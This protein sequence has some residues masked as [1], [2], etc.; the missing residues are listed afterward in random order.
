[1]AALFHHI[2]PQKNGLFCLFF[3]GW[4]ERSKKEKSKRKRNS[5]NF[6]VKFANDVT[7]RFNLVFSV[8]A[9]TTEK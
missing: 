5:F 6:G 3:S 9:R 2:A 1:M 8:H 4:N 7:L